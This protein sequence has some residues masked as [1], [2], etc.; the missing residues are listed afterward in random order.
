MAKRFAVEVFV[1]ERHVVN[2]HA[3]NEDKA[4]N[5]AKKAFWRSKMGYMK[6]KHKDGVISVH[7]DEDYNFRAS[8]GHVEEEE[9]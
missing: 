6:V 1:T 4:R 7:F 8:T 9:E 3:V 2:V 5:K